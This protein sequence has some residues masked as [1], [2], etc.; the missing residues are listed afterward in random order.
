MIY[1]YLSILYTCIAAVRRVAPTLRAITSFLG[2]F[3]DLFHRPICKDF[4]LT[5]TLLSTGCM[6]HYCSVNSR[7][8]RALFRDPTFKNLGIYTIEREP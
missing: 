2:Y 8:A 3:D 7:G 1:S 6:L 5:F 4:R